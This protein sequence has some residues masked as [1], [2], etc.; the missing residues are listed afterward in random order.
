[1]VSNYIG[2]DA[3]Y[4]ELTDIERNASAIESAVFVVDAYHSEDFGV[5]VG[6]DIKSQINERI[7]TNGFFGCGFVG[8]RIVYLNIGIG[9]DGTCSAGESHFGSCLALGNIGEQG[10]D[11]GSG[12]CI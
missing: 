4:P 6:A 7:T 5:F 12:K 10:G 3:F 2:D 1:M 8:Y 9:N 11:E